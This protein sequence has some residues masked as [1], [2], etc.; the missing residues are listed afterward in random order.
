M[1]RTKLGMLLHNSIRNDEIRRRTK[2]SDIVLNIGKFKW[3][4]AGHAISRTTIREERTLNSDRISVKGQVAFNIG[5]LM[6]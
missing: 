4:W 5:E 3:Q 1:R 6:T 2:I